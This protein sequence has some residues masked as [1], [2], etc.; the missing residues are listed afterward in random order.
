M[1]VEAAS[2]AT[3]LE[4]LSSG[5][6]VVAATL[7][8]VL[9]SAPLPLGATMWVHEDGGLEGSVTGG[10]VEGAL[11][12]E[13]HAVLAG[14]P[15]RVSTFGISDELAGDVGLMC[16]GTVRIFVGE[17][18]DTEPVR[19][20]LSAAQEG[21]AAVL[22]TLLDGPSAGRRMAIVDGE[23]VGSLGAGDLLDSSVAR[24][25]AGLVAQGASMIRRYGDD[26]AVMG[27]DLRV[28]VH[29]FAPP[30]RM[31]IVGAIDFSAALAAMARELGYDVS[32]CDPRTAFASSTRFSRAATV[33]TKWPDEHLPSL[34][35][36]PRDAVLVFSHDPKLDEPALIAALRTGA[37]YIGAL[38]SRRTQAARRE[39]LLAAGVSEADA[40]RIVA[41]CGLDLGAS[42]PA[43]TAVS[44][45]GEIIALRSGRRPERLVDTEGPIRRPASA[46]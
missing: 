7:V 20:A 5:R 28:F 13:A 25:A 17:V 3:A 35:L 40:D 41:P 18:D 36:G 14:R 38:G 30:P 39:R 46:V 37:G 19:A 8:E 9:G 2:S 32:I 34:D 11:A 12:E 26:G 33:V 45:L 44:V 6:R 43:E 29:A 4:W 27:D 42:T 16:G 22:A 24:E 21:R 23:V 1:S 31:V 10:C 15:P